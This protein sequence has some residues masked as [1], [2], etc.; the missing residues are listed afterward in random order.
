MRQR[1]L[2]LML[3]ILIPAGIYG[4]NYLN[5][6][7][8]FQ[9]I[10]E[11]KPQYQGIEIHAYYY[12]FITPSKLVIDVMHVE[13]ASSLDVFSTLIDFAKKNES[14]HYQQVILAYKGS[15]KFIVAGDA[16]S[17]L[18]AD[19]G[20]DLFP[21]MQSFLKQVQDLHGVQPFSIDASHSISDLAAEFQR[22]HEQWYASE[23]GNHLKP[24]DQAAAR[25][26]M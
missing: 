4:F 21:V 10:L 20:K 14:K 9:Q 17:E 18:S 6:E 1:L 11:S 24:F 2:L 5:L 13:N 25:G 8:P 26:V 22:F 19:H 3:A 12:N 15:A 16:F 7:R 23:P